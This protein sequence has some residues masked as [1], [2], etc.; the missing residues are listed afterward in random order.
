MD[1]G[2]PLSRKRSNNEWTLMGVGNHTCFMSISP[3]RLHEY[4]RESSLQ[5]HDSPCHEWGEIEYLPQQDGIQR[6]SAD[7]P[8]GRQDLQQIHQFHG[9]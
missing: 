4:Y 7:V 9:G 6:W 1:L 8:R 5:C 2:H 3:R